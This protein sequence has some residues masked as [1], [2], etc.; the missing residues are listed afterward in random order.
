MDEKMHIRIGAKMREALE[1]KVTIT[2]SD[3][4]VCTRSSGPDKRDVELLIQSQEL[5][6]SMKVRMLGEVVAV[7]W[8]RAEQGDVPYVAEFQEGEFAGLKTDCSLAILI[9]R[10]FGGSSKDGGD[11]QD[12]LNSDQVEAQKE[13][14]TVE[15]G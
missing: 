7:T 14:A 8:L 11:K 6:I 1:K 15:E 12:T 5:N 2:V 13:P 4:L 10:I 3:F 9:R